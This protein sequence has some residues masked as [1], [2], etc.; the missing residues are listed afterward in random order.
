MAFAK[1]L[2]VQNVIPLARSLSFAG[3]LFRG[4]IFL[5]STNSGLSVEFQSRSE[6]YGDFLAFQFIDYTGGR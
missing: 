5:A 4:H 6:D 2:S 1:R 3:S